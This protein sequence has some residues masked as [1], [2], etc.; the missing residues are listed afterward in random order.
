MTSTT[1]QAGYPVRLTGELDR[2]LSR[3][4]WLVKMFLA[5]PHYVVLA[6]LW[7]AFLIT[8]V[9]A[10]FAILFT[11]RYPRS[12][13][14]FNVG[15]MRWNWRS[16]STSTPPLVPTDTRRSPWPGLITRQTSMSPT[17][18]VSPVAWS[19]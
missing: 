16:A 18:N 13:F 12:L 8:T 3:W 7:V 14:D 4:L 15:V 17:P 5:I 6:F 19:W 9:I 11:G 1:S 10:G 2:N